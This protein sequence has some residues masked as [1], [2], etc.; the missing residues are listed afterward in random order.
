MHDASVDRL[1]V[2][3]VEDDEAL[4]EAMVDALSDEGYSVVTATNGKEAL[5]LL[6]ET[7][8]LPGLVLL[9]LMMPVMNGWS[10]L[11]AVRQDPRL[12]SLQVCIISAVPHTQVPRDV[13]CAFQKPIDLNKLIEVV[14]AH[15][16][17]Q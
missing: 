4:R 10:F 1:T 5:E 11:G 8:P 12:R 2:L 14:D 7:A 16:H 13:I 15:C 6:G 3:V 9:D 17:P